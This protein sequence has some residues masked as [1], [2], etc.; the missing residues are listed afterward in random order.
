MRSRHCSGPAAGSSDDQKP[1]GRAHAFV[2]AF[3]ETPPKTTLPGPELDNLRAIT[4][5]AHRHGGR[6]YSI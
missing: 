3:Q 4:E 1:S 6:K 5:P 2:G